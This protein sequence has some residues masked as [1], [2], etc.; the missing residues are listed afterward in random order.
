[1]AEEVIPAPARPKGKAELAMFGGQ[2]PDE[3]KGELGLLVRV[4]QAL[5]VTGVR[6]T[7]EPKGSTED[8]QPKEETITS[9]ISEI[10]AITVKGLDG[11]QYYCYTSLEINGEWRKS[12]QNFNRWR[13]KDPKPAASPKRKNQEASKK[14]PPAKRPKAGPK[15]AMPKATARLNN[16]KASEWII[17]NVLLNEAL[18]GNKNKNIRGD[19]GE[20]IFAMVAP[21]IFGVSWDKVKIVG[22]HSKRGR[23]D[24]GRDIIIT[25]NK[26]STT[27]VVDFKAW[28]EGTVS[29]K[30]ARSI[31][32]ALTAI[33]MNTN[34]GVGIV[35]TNRH[36]S[37][38]AEQYKSDYNTNAPQKFHQDKGSTVEL[39]DGKELKTQIALAINKDETDG[40]WDKTAIHFI[41]DVLCYLDFKELIEC[42]GARE[43][44]SREKLKEKVGCELAKLFKPS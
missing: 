40:G 38:E 24:G 35:A 22:A 33:R 10:N 20:I 5:T 37:D 44:D 29:A 42:E 12:S 4:P 39:W 13:L 36:F 41:A 3:R 28:K 23:G 8:R 19:I 25:D 9:G 11:G 31:G 27:Y 16:E 15:I 21:A 34:R 1:M 43:D 6:V 32:G 26:K 14:A 17:S 30:D 18:D 2:A 7:C